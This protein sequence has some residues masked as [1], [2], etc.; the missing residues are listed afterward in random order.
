VAYF[1][2][3]TKEDLLS[4]VL[5]CLA[6]IQASARVA[7]ICYDYQDTVRGAPEDLKGIETEIKNVQETLES[8][9]GLLEKKDPHWNP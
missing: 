3:C 4:I 2:Q 7:K 6:V 5:G 8:I 9:N 1:Q